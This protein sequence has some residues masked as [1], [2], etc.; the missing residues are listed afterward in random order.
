MSTLNAVGWA[1]INWNAPTA[2]RTRS[3][4]CSAYVVVWFFWKG[5]NWARIVVLLTSLWAILNLLAW[6]RLGRFGKVMV[7]GEGG[8]AVF[9]LCWL[10]TADVRVFFKMNSDG[11]I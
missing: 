1:I 8:L 3:L 11:R 9:L 5:R 4:S 7:G 10:N 2:T 6:N